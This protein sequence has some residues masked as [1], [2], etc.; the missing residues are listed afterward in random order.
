MCQ[1]GHLTSLTQHN[2]S[3][4]SHIISPPLQMWKLRPGEMKSFGQ[5]DIDKVHRIQDSDTGLL[6]QS[7]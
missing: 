6:T 5:S 1:P 2:N 7:P 4:A 3:E